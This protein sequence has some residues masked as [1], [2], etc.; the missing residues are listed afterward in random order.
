MNANTHLRINKV[1]LEDELK[2]IIDYLEDEISSDAS[3]IDDLGTN[4]SYVVKL[5][6]NIFEKTLQRHCKA[7]FC[8]LAEYLLT[9][10]FLE[11]KYIFPILDYLEWDNIM[12]FPAIINDNINGFVRFIEF[13]DEKNITF[14]CSAGYV[15]NCL[16]KL[17]GDKN[18]LAIDLIKEN[19]LKLK[20]SDIDCLDDSILKGIKELQDR[21]YTLMK[22]RSVFI[23]LLSKKHLAIKLLEYGISK[24]IIDKYF[25]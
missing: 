10:D 17:A 24:K 11:K 20:D 3:D 7:T 13:A 15:V 12:I 5:A 19:K 8:K 18:L 1:V 21:N 6:N 25:D 16:V 23:D 22:K 9:Y 4:V 14:N 2:K